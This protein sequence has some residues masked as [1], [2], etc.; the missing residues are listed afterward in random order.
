[1]STFVLQLPN[2]F[3]D[4]D[5]D[6]MSYVDGG[7][8]YSTTY[9]NNDGIVKLGAKFGMN[10]VA[11]KGAV[12]LLLASAV[13][14]VVALAAVGIWIT[15]VYWG[16]TNVA[17]LITAMQYFKSYG[18]YTINENIVAGVTLSRWVTR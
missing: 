4:I 3:V 1:M 17:A 18:S 9:Y 6:E 16:A 7:T 15:N 5:R 11:L 2:S 13:T 10:L 14:V 12:V 8:T